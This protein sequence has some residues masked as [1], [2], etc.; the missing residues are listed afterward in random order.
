M[1]LARSSILLSLLFSI[2]CISA[3]TKGNR[4]AYLDESDPFYVGLQF[5]KLTTPQWVADSNVEAV[6]ILAIDDMRDPA[7]YETFLRPMLERLKKIDGRAPLS[8]FCNALDPT[9]PQLQAW[10]KEGLSLEIHTLSHPCPL[11][12][13]GDFTAAENTYH[14]CVDLLNRL[15]GNKPVAFRMPCCDSMN[16]PSPRF[17]AE[18]FNSTNAAGQ[19]LTIDSSVMNIPTAD[20]SSVPRDLVVDKSGAPR[21]QKYLVTQTNAISRVSMKSFVTTIRDYPYPYVIGNRC[22]EFPAMVPSDWE[23]NNLHGPTNPVTVADWKAALD[24]TVLKQ[25]TFTFIFHPH[26]WIRSDQMVEF[27]DYAVQRYG[28]K[29][30]FVTF[31]EAQDQ[32]DKHLLAGQALRGVRGEDNGVRLI[33][34]N[35]DGYIDVVS[36]AKTRLWSPQKRLWKESASPTPI[37]AASRFGTVDQ[38]AI[39]IRRAEADGKATQGAWRFQDGEWIADDSLLAGF[40]ARTAIEGRDNG[41]RLRDINNDGDC[42]LIVANSNESAI[43][44]WSQQKKSWQKLA[45]ALPQGAQFVDKVGK[46]FGLR[47]VDLNEDGYDDVI[48]SNPEAY[49]VFLFMPKPVQNWDFEA[50][51]T[52]KVRRGERAGSDP[53]AVPIIARSGPHANNGA[54]FHSSHLWIQNEDTAHLPDKVD[55]RSFDQLLA[56]DSPSPKSPEESL[57]C[58]KLRPGFRAELVAAEPLTTDPVAFDWGADG[59]LWVVDM[60]DYPLGLDGKGKPGGVVRCLEDTDNDGNYDKSTVFLSDLNFPNG[61]MPWRKGVIVSAAPEIFY[62]EDRDGDG[63]ADFRVTLLEGFGQGNQQHRVNGF[64]YGLDNWVY[65]ANGD[66]SGMIRAVGTFMGKSERSEEVNLRGHDLRFRPDDGSFE[67]IEGQTQFG[68][69]RDDWGNWFGNNNPSWGWHYWIAERYATRNRYVPIRSMRQYLANYPKS[70]HVFAVSEPLQRFNWP[71]LVNTLTSGNS[72]TPYRDELFGAAFENSFFVSEPAHNVVHREEFF[73]QGPTFDSRRP[74]DEKEIEFVASTDNWFRPTMLKTGPDGAL[75]IADM[76]RLVIEHT[77]YALPGMEKQIDVRAGDDRGRI[78]R[79]SPEN[80]RPRKIPRLDKLNTAGLVGALD[81]PSG[82]QRDTAQRL[83]VQARDKSAPELLRKLF[84]ASQNAK[85]RLHALCTLD[86]LGALQTKDLQEGW[87]DSHPMVRAHAVRLSETIKAKGDFAKL[88]GLAGDPDIRVRY[89]LALTLGEPQW[90]DQE[91]GAALARIAAKDPENPQMQAAIMSSAP[92]CLESLVAELQKSGNKV[93]LPLRDQLLQL[94]TAEDRQSAIASV[95]KSALNPGHDPAGFSLLNSFLDALRRRGISL[96]EYERQCSGELR[97][98]LRN[99]PTLKANAETVAFNSSVKEQE[100]AAALRLL[101]RLSPQPETLRHLTDLLAANQPSAV[102]KATLNALGEARDSQVATMVLQH[103][104]RLSPTMRVDAM[105]LLLSNPDWTQSILSAIAQ[106]QLAAAAVPASARQRLLKHRDARVRDRAVDLFAKASTDRQ[107][108]VREYRTAKIGNAQN[109]A[110][111]F[112]QHCASCHNLRGEGTALGPDLA[113]LTDK[114][115][116]SLLVAILDPNQS[117]ETPFVNYNVVTRDGRELSG[118]IASES[119]TSVTLR[120]A[121]GMEY[122]LLRDD[123]KEITSSGLSLMP[124]GLEQALNPQQMADLIQ[125]VL[126]E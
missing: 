32:L 51:W 108:V 107:R 16:S 3:P 122:V 25:G 49:G 42:E 63:K 68:R 5:P 103:W 86:G 35:G 117:V 120:A 76:Y 11:L 33:D 1:S 100:R 27:I 64:E 45:Y 112:R 95:L 78:Y 126:A 91:A 55:R 19:F 125:Y 124:E 9:N 65:A 97:D 22:W 89:Q 57:A 13:K 8:I 115:V 119:G 7:K 59:K 34:L 96:N 118:I 58:L 111:L 99:V 56:F 80:T 38:R 4:L 20:D 28:N 116:E 70:T 87:V 2:S 29:V 90:P 15:P 85:A 98:L 73:P 114:S 93:A 71:N 110:A 54:W 109:G 72:L 24:I 123:I 52:R 26:G 104:S 6:V 61:I 39:L 48:F 83:L 43:Y 14:G 79:V 60:I 75:Y 67:M 30:K 10:L 50:G 101:G 31:R 81:S 77:E 53:Y 74:A 88:F 82:W 41:V 84:V 121:G 69:H 37:D 113:T 92:A 66:S 17:Y 94:A 46:D 44:S 18:M 12:R 23:A 106:N 62:A 102:Q 40:T 21:F 36:T 47:F 105:E